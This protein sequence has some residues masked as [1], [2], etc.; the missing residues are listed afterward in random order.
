MITT[1][2]RFQ[3]GNAKSFVSEREYTRAMS[4]VHQA[5]GIEWQSKMLPLHFKKSA[6]AKYAYKP[7]TS[8]YLEWKKKK[9]KQRRPMKNG[10]YVEGSGE[11]DL[12]LSGDMRD[13]MLGPAV[14]R[15]FPTRVSINLTGPRY[16]TMRTN[17]NQPDKLLEV[18][19]TT[20]RERVELAKVAETAFERMA[21]GWSRPY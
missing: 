9:W 17:S 14:I 2:L 4:A 21:A 18:A 16:M 15:A 1:Q 19:T 12:V 6:Q 10:Q 8:K 20:E 11:T 7:R 5:V 13:M 3:P